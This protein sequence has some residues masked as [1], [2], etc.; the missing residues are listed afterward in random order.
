MACAEGLKSL[1]KTLAVIVASRSSPSP[2]VAKGADLS[3][4]PR[5]ARHCGITMKGI[6]GGGVS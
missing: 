4:S 5:A 2:L 3:E 6:A 1:A